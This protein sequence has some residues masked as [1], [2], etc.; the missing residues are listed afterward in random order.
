MS[1]MKYTEI[2]QVMQTLLPCT[3]RVHGD[4]KILRRRV[5]QERKRDKR[6]LG[7][8]PQQGDLRLSGP[9][10]GQGAGSRVRT[11]DRRVPAD[12]RADS[13]ATVLPT[14]PEVQKR[15]THTDK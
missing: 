11:R 14:P 9:P 4:L 15:T 7:R 12:L 8:G 5:L 13:Q 1:R 3:S 10:P 2:R 6:G